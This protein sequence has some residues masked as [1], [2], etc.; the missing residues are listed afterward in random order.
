MISN[1]SFHLSP[2][3]F[4]RVELAISWQSN[5]GVTIC[6]GNVVY[7]IL[8][9][10]SFSISRSWLLFKFFWHCV[11]FFD[12][13][14]ISPIFIFKKLLVNGLFNCTEWYGALSITIIELGF[15]FCTKVTIQFLKTVAIYQN[16][17]HNLFFFLVKIF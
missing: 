1:F 5:D 7:N 17:N 13:Y 4:N 3:Q 2:N 8:F 9:L 6:L 12:N 15:I 16:D 10:F 14:L 11:L